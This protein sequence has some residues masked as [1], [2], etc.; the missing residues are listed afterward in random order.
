MVDVVFWMVFALWCDG[1]M[2]ANVS[3]VRIVSLYLFDETDTQR[4]M[5]CLKRQADSSK[6]SSDTLLA[7]LHVNMQSRF[8]EFRCRMSPELST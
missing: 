2:D 5:T 7:C 6:G 4:I 1:A 8:D 3:T